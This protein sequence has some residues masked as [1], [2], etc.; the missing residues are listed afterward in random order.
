MKTFLVFII[1][2]FLC[3]AHEVDFGFNI[4]YRPIHFWV[5][6]NQYTGDM[7]SESTVDIPGN[8]KEKANNVCVEE[9]KQK[10]PELPVDLEY[11]HLALLTGSNYPEGSKHP[12]DF[13]IPNKEKRSIYRRDG[14]TLISKT[15]SRYFNPDVEFVEGGV[16]PIDDIRHIWT[17][18]KSD[19]TLGWNCNNWKSNSNSLDFSNRGSTS[20]FE[21]SVVITNK[22]RFSIGAF[23]KCNQLRYIICISF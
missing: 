18:I 23:T 8:S 4:E 12:K 15:Y 2:I 5:T 16:P 7:E 9:N 21:N 3:C 10:K 22:K 11:Q 17:G 6:N 14:I 20:E 13:D 19:G 1:G